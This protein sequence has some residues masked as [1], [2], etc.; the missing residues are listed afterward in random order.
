MARPGPRD[1]SNS[2]TVPDLHLRQAFGAVFHCSRSLGPAELV[3][4]G[5]AKMRRGRL[6]LLAAA[7]LVG[8]AQTCRV[9]SFK[10]LLSAPSHAAVCGRF[11]GG[12]RL[13][14]WL[15]SVVQAGGGL[16]PALGGAQRGASGFDVPPELRDGLRRAGALAG[17]RRARHSL[18]VQLSHIEDV[19]T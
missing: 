7:A 2:L 16:R 3:G 18:Q 19:T 9:V 4:F 10:G 17:H 6:L 8:H 13:L 14:Q 15:D 12:A 5:L 11:G 1:R